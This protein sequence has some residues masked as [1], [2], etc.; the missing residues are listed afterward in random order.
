MEDI[1]QKYKKEK[2]NKNIIIVVTSFML[3]LGLNFLL[4][5]TNNG[6]YL[7]SSV[8]NSQI[9][10]EKQADLYLET[11]KNSG[12]NVVNLKTSKEISQVKS[13]SLSIV[14]NK[15]NIK[16]KDK[17]L[18]I[19]QAELINVIENDGFNTI[20]INFKNPT[21]IKVGEDILNIVFE[22]QNVWEMESIN[23]VNSNITDNEG[24]IF[25]LSTSGIEF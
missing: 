3:A 1:I 17:L 10:W 14:Y 9:T 20:I 7:T 22:K 16:V 8:L 19:D 21:N 11:V 12:N 24:N 6:K 15:E 2:R 13:L 25:S 4:V 18:S 23:L 5:N